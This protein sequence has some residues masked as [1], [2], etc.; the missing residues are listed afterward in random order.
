MKVCKGGQAKNPPWTNTRLHHLECQFDI[1]APKKM[2]HIS[3]SGQF[4]SP[5][6]I[7]PVCV[8]AHSHGAPSFAVGLLVQLD[9]HV[10]KRAG[11]PRDQPLE[12][13]GVKQRVWEAC[14]AGLTYR[15]WFLLLR[16]LGT[17]VASLK[18]LCFPQKAGT[19]SMFIW[20]GWGEAM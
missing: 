10:V 13:E 5:P 7:R 9:G 12:R 16:G 15:L 20:N 4:N 3:P 2:A 18:M 6:L 19:Q 14:R 8:K 17:S 11:L 1:L